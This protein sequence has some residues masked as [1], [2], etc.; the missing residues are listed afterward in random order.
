MED[1]IGSL[2]VGKK[3]DLI[4]LDHNLFDVDPYRIHD[5]R[6]LLTMFDGDVVYRASESE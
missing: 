1:Q 3:A 2:E 5:T 6:V 4:V